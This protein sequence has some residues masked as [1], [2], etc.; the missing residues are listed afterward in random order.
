[1]QTPAQISF[2][3]LPHSDAIEGDILK[4][5][6]KLEQVYPDIISCHVV[7]SASHRHHHQGNL[8]GV[9]IKLSVPDKEIVVSNDQHDN[10]AHEDAYVALRDAFDA[11]RRQL[12]DY[13]RVRRRQVKSHTAPLHGVVIQLDPEGDSGIIH[14]ADGRQVYFH[15]NSVIGGFE[16]L[17]AG[18]EVRFHEG[19]GDDGPRATTVHIVGKHHVTGQ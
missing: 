12:E 17:E 19:E 18:S 1:M 7:V 16:R 4:K 5:V 9:R 2:K 14:T 8:Y 13:S 6:A 15:R 3:G 11:A 10:H